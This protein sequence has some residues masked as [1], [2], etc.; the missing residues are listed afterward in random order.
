MAG[1]DSTVEYLRCQL[2]D[3]GDGLAAAFVTLSMAPHPPACEMLAIRLTGAMK[4]LR[5]L[6]EAQRRKEGAE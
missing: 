1:P 2:Q 5:H 4:H 6:A 3:I